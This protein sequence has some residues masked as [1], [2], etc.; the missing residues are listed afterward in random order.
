MTIQLWTLIFQGL[1]AL[2][3]FITLGIFIFAA[4][5]LKELR[6]NLEDSRNWNKMS[7]AFSLLPTH[8]QFIEIEKTLNDSFIK[9]IDR[10][11][12]LT[13]FETSELFKEENSQLRT[14][15]KNY[16]NEFESYCIAINMGIVHYEVAE[17][18]YF[19]KL[20]RHFI[21]MKPFINRLRTD[22]NEQ[23]IYEEIEHVVS[24][25]SKQLS[26]NAGY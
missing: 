26:D 17:R 22:Q 13:E 8:S 15:L 6:K 19:H 4:L 9:F 7:T 21:E 2:S 12:P 20:R 5:Q 3:T 25:F 1:A 23:R 16:L 14:E 10:T 24:M 11:G 18:K